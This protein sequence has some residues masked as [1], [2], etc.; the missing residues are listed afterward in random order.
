MRCRAGQWTHHGVDA[1]GIAGR[2][3]H[4]GLASQLE[5]T[6]NDDGAAERSK[7]ATFLQNREYVT[8][9]VSLH[10]ARYN[11]SY[12]MTQFVAGLLQIVLSDTKRVLT[13]L[14]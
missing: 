12:S 8:V 6:A 9:T 5:L 10:G 14:L 11:S 13:I 1:T 3:S 2:K 4:F 7:F